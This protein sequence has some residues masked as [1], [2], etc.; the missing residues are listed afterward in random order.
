[1]IR[2]A[3]VPERASADDYRTTLDNI[4]QNILVLLRKESE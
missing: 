3:D 1:M 4:A 2:L